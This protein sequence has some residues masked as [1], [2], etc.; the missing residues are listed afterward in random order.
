MFEQT[1]SF[2]PYGYYGQPVTMGTG[3]Q[4]M[5]MPKQTLYKSNYTPEEYNR[6]MNEGPAFTLY[7]TE[8]EVLMAKCNHRS[9]TGLEQDDPIIDLPDGRCQCRVCKYI[10]RPVNYNETID[11]IQEAVDRVIDIAQTIKMIYF[12]M[13]QETT[14][15]FWTIIPLLTKL[16]HFFQ[17]AVED[18]NRSNGQMNYRYNSRNMGTL[19]L[20]SR[21]IGSIG[22][23]MGMPGMAPNPQMYT[24]GAN[25][26]MMGQPQ[27]GPMGQPMMGSF[28]T[29]MYGP[30]QQPYQPQQ[31]GY[32]YNPQQQAQQ[33]S[34][35]QQ[36]PVA[37]EPAADATADKNFKA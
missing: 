27:M 26:G 21:F 28:G 14:E 6:L 18:F 37:T 4:F 9:L 5:G 30:V 12:N 19:D 25:P 16:P 11:D 13:P 10:F 1:Q 3:N 34:Q 8:D 7:P 23:M 2:N 33:Q 29:P 24:A 36:A 20:Y 15:Q 31:Q 32:A 17:M 22:G 35:P